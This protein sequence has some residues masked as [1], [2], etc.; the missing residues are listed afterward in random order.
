MAVVTHDH[1]T[2]VA[3]IGKRGTIQQGEIS[4][5]VFKYC[6]P[7][8]RDLSHLVHIMLRLFIEIDATGR[9]C[10][11]R[12]SHFNNLVDRIIFM[13]QEVTRKTGAIIPPAS[14][15]EKTFRA[16]GVFFFTRFFKCFPVNGFFGSQRINFIYPGSIG[17]VPVG[18]DFY[19]VDVSQQSFFNS[20]SCL[21]IAIG[22]PS[23]V[24]QL[25][26]HAS[27]SDHI[28]DGEYFLRVP[29]KTFF[30]IHMFARTCGIHG[31]SWMP[32][33]RCSNNHRIYIRRLQKILVFLVFLWLSAIISVQAFPVHVCSS[34]C[35]FIPSDAEQ[36][37]NTID[38]NIQII[39]FL[40][41]SI[42]LVVTVPVSTFLPVL[43]QGWQGESCTF[44]KLLAPNAITYNPKP[45]GFPVPHF[46]GFRGSYTAHVQFLPQ[47][48]V[49]V[50]VQF[51]F[52][53]YTKCKS[54]EHRDSCHPF[55]QFSSV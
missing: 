7:D 11:G 5:R 29:C 4:F 15:S 55:Q 36:V 32:V 33:I 8:I 6:I 52:P 34:L 41:F 20:F 16:E 50:V 46:P 13:G 23:L 21:H 47:L 53:P 12:N 48:M 42:P 31:D 28:P 2:A 14:P 24:A 18:A 30:H 44:E 35:G 19:Q 1:L 22:L 38:H 25:E 9:D 27:L 49:P 17:R 3:V 51:L 54:T 10:R 45:Q 39:L 37:T 43:Q 40:E 26:N